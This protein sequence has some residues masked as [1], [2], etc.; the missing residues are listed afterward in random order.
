MALHNLPDS[1]S[2]KPAAKQ[3]GPK[4]KPPTSKTIHP[5]PLFNANWERI[6]A[7]LAAN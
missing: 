4:K 5:A 1:A 6:A 3:G 7:R 2:K